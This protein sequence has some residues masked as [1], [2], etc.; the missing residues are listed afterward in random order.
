MSNSSI[1]IL[2]L[3]QNEIAEIKSRYLLN[4]KDLSCFQTLRCCI[5][6]AHKGILADYVEIL[7]N[8]SNTLK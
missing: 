3:I 8:Q 2:L 6:H 4:Y 5:Y 1:D 7:E